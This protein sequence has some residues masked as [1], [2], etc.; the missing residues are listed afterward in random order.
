MVI[1]V[2]VSEIDESE[3]PPNVYGTIVWQ[4]A[5]VFNV[6]L[7]TEEKITLRG[8]V[9]HIE[10]GNV[11]DST[12]HVI[13]ALYIGNVLYTVSDNKIKMNSL[14]DLSEINTLDLTN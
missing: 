10:D 6:S 13:R 4:G 11:Y 3:V 12:N 2:L 8:M 9:T 7:E 1:P 14:S 5:Y